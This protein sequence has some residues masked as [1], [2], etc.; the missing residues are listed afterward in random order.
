MNRY[1]SIL[2]ITAIFTV[3]FFS[4]TSNSQDCSAVLCSQFA[5]QSVNSTMKAGST[6]NVVVAFRNNGSYNWSNG[7]IRL[8][9]YDPRMNPNENN[10][11]GVDNVPIQSSAVTE[12]E[13]KIA[14]TIT[15]PKTPG[16]YFFQ[17]QLQSDGVFFGEKTTLVNITV[18]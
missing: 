15:A 9:F 12:Q 2:A 18:K 16:V 10:V 14:F 1:K 11:W 13:T 17:W 3:L 5:G 4:K 6:Q 8:A 7:N